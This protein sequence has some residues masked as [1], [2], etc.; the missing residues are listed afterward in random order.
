MPEEK[1]IIIQDRTIFHDFSVS[2]PEKDVGRFLG[3]LERNRWKCNEKGIHKKQPLVVDLDQII[4]EE[5]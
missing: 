4:Q 3:I 1:T 5:K 2:I